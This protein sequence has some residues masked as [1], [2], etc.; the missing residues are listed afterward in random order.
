MKTVLPL[1]IP[2]RRDNVRLRAELLPANRQGSAH[3]QKLIPISFQ[4]SRNGK[5]NKE[6]T[7]F[8]SKCCRLV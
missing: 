2:A 6:M 8:D 4:Y 5:N 7:T 1:T 3:H